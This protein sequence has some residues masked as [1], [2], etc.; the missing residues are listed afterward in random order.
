VGSLI[1]FS[2][3]APEA[4]PISNVA[5]PA[6]SWRTSQ[7]AGS[8]L[9]SRAFPASGFKPEGPG[10]R[11]AIPDWFWPH[12]ALAQSMLQRGSLPPLEGRWGRGS[13]ISPAS[14]LSATHRLSP[15]SREPTQ[16]TLPALAQLADRQP[17]HRG[18]TRQ[19]AS[20]DKPIWVHNYK[21]VESISRI[22]SM[23]N[24]RAISTVTFRIILIGMTR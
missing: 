12:G 17:A 13:A 1:R 6:V 21:L 23:G 19:P 10:V 4:T 18:G 8:N 5:S 22:S 11:D 20:C 7:E 15:E 16:S 9:G 14:R 2:P 3:A 24:S